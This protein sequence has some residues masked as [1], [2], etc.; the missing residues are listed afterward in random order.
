[1]TRLTQASGDQLQ[2]LLMHGEHL[3]DRIEERTTRLNQ[4]PAGALNVLLGICVGMLIAYGVHYEL[5]AVDFDIVGP[6][7][8]GAGAA[9]GRLIGRDRSGRKREER[10]RL[11]KLEAGSRLQQALQIVDFLRSQGRLLPPEVRDGAWAEV[12]RL[13]S[14][15]AG[16]PTAPTTLLGKMLP[17]SDKAA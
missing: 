6:L 2:G 12:N 8:G 16:A 15:Q 7:M 9:L 13:I 10:L 17:S 11:E 3:L 4:L 5:P 14:N 1:M